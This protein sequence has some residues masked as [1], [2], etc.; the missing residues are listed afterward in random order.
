MT[1]ISLRTKLLIGTVGITILLGS[2]LIIFIRTSVSDK[3]EIELQ[4]RGII[5]ANDI[6]IESISYLLSEDII[7]LK[8]LL[9]NHKN[10]AEDTEYII[11]VDSENKVLAHT[12]GKKFPVALEGIN[13]VG[14]E[15]EYNVQYLNTKKGEILDIAVPILE[16]ELGVLRLGISAKPIFESINN[17]TQM[18]GYIIIGILILIGGITVILATLVTKPVLELT[19][20]AKK[21]GSGNLEYRVN[22]KS[23]DEIEQLARAFNQ[24]ARDLETTTVSRDKLSKEI[25]ERK[26]LEG[27]LRNLSLTDELTGL[28]NRRGFFTLAE[29]YLKL[30][31]RQKRK[32]FMLYADL[33]NLKC[34]NDT[35]GHQEGDIMLIEIAKILKESYRESDIIARIGGDEFVV[36]PVG[37]TKFD[38]KILY[39]RLQEIIETIN[40]KINRR[41]KISISVG[42]VH[43]DPEQPC[44]IDELIAHA[45]KLMYEQKRHKKKYSQ[46]T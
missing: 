38:A 41:Y 37:F 33:D 9:H 40:A 12:F 22:I 2:M 44:S 32:V 17:I 8:L 16:G 23:N 36:L 20:S 15:Q 5:L 29:Q 27:K 14:P 21:I 31:N 25:A 43:Y 45:D 39:T 28:H 4:K 46:Q 34:I 1:F 26:K 10:T 6:S 35:F 3:L 19:N 30:I 42:I 24:M 7:N 13:I 11:I 18:I